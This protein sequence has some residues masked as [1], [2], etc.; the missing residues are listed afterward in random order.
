M[1]RYTM[2]AFIFIFSVFLMSPVVYGIG[3][4]STYNRNATGDIFSEDGVLIQT[5]GR[6]R[7]IKSLHTVVIYLE[8]PHFPEDLIN[9]VR[10]LGRFIVK[11]ETCE[12]CNVSFSTSIKER[13][14]T[15][16]TKLTR[17]AHDL[18]LKLR[19]SDSRYKRSILDPVYKTVGLATNKDV[20]RL[21]QAVQ[22][23]TSNTEILFHNEELMSSFLKTFVSNIT[24]NFDQF[25]MAV[26]HLHDFLLTE[27]AAI[28]TINIELHIIR[29]S[30]DIESAIN[31]MQVAI[32]HLRDTLD[33]WHRLITALDRGQ[34]TA[35][36]ISESQL[37]EIL[38][39]IKETE[40]YSL[41][42]NWIYENAKVSYLSSDNDHIYFNFLIPT[43]SAEQYLKYN[44]NTY[45]V[46]WKSNDS[47]NND[48]LRRLIV[49]SSIAI[50]ASS[51]SWFIYQESHCMGSNP[52]ACVVT[53]LR[54]TK[55]C[56]T[57]LINNELMD[58]C[59]FHV[60]PRN[61]RT[62][63]IHRSE[64]ASQAEFVVLS[65]FIPVTL[66]KRCNDRPA[67]PYIVNKIVKFRINP[68]CYIDNEEFQIRPVNVRTIRQSQTPPL[69]Y[70]R[71]APL[72]ISLPKTV[73]D[74]FI[75]DLKK[76][77]S[78]RIQAGELPGLFDIKPS[79]LSDLLFDG[80]SFI[81]I[82]VSSISL[83]IS[84]ALLS[85][86]IIKYARRHKCCTRVLHKKLIPENFQ[87]TSEERDD[88]RLEETPVLKTTEQ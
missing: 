72:N 74:M 35:D 56:A 8:R 77:K 85:M 18:D 37:N 25:D 26:Q 39:E 44:F 22:L 4:S 15:R 88:D 69:T 86:I 14:E 48:V 10:T 81:S 45:L 36:L 76:Y 27:G 28:S 23:Q 11:A 7:S 83:G 29:L 63:E 6:I 12:N 16:I 20:S 13:W 33:R 51:A 49:P 21:K 55:S 65:P 52:I 58:S 2:Q 66:N 64:L 43:L 40:H 46:P 53:S 1:V 54:L 5:D 62:L 82:I 79:T 9:R 87:M 42:L 19:E 71:L 61:G 34:L 73:P 70:L 78:R 84:L 38:G 31:D 59:S 68:N 50:S 3:T 57:A 67:R 32:D 47:Y 60:E 17:Q 75:K 80:P 24:G 41:S 30:H